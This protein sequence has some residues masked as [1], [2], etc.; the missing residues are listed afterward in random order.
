MSPLSGIGQLFAYDILKSLDRL[1]GNLTAVGQLENWCL[2][3]C[4]VGSV[5]WSP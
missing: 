2:V 1:V 3:A 4:L 5:L